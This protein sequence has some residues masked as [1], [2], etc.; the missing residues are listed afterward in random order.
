MTPVKIHNVRIKNIDLVISDHYLSSVVPLIAKEI[1]GGE[2]ALVDQIE[3]DF[4]EGDIIIDIGGHVGMFSLYLAK[5]FPFI[6]IYAFEPAFENWRNF[7]RNIK[8]N[9]VTNIILYHLAVTGDGKNVKLQYD[10]NSNWGVS[11]VEQVNCSHRETSYKKETVKSITLDQIF[12]KHTIDKLILLKIDCE[13]AEFEI[14]YGS[15]CLSKIDYIV[16]ETHGFDNQKNSRK[17]LLEFLAKNF[18][19]DKMAFSG[20]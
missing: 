3:K 20:W 7:K 15:K 13:G 14:F 11:T 19:Q 12:A 17:F 1:N 9:N 4:K 2:Y 8:L 10:P 6:K 16:G 18:D 5:K